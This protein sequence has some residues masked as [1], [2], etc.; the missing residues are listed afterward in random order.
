MSALTQALLAAAGIG[1]VMVA[2]ALVIALLVT[3]GKV[4]RLQAAGLGR[5]VP[6]PAPASIAVPMAT[7]TRADDA[8]AD[9]AAA[10]A[11]A[12]VVSRQRSG[13]AGERPLRHAAMRAPMPWER[14]GAERIEAH[15]GDTITVI[16]VAP[17]SG[18][19]KRQGRLEAMQ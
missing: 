3:L 6:A 4:S 14:A 17:G 16:Y 15:Y 19:W 11:V 10:L 8:L 5:S 2:L 7:P 9:Q 18:N 1:L 12:L 13:S